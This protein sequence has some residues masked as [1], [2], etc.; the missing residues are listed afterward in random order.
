M[1]ERRWRACA[2]VKFTLPEKYPEMSPDG[3]KFSLLGSEWMSEM[4]ARDHM[5]DMRREVTSDAWLFW[6]EP[7]NMT[8]DEVKK[9]RPGDVR[10]ACDYVPEDAI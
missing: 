7:E 8:P 1:N 4:G 3:R 9:Y 6:L 10:D 2:F 5:W